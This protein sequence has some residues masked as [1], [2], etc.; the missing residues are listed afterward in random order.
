MTLALRWGRS[1]YE[2]EDALA[3]ERR[4]LSELGVDLRFFAGNDPPLDGV[5]V[6]I[7]PSGS[8][9]DA[10]ILRRAEALRLVVATTSG[11]DHIDVAAARAREI[12]VARCPLA[13]RDA[14]VDTSVGMGL[15][16]VRQLG[17]LHRQAEAGVWARQELPTRATGKIRGMGVGIVGLGVIGSRAAEVWAA[18]GAEVVVCDPAR[19]GTVS[20][21]ELVASCELIT[22]HCSLPPS[23][24][25]LV[26]ANALAAMAD[27]TVL[28]NTARG[29]CLDLEAVEA[30]HHLGGLGLDVFSREPWPHLERLASRP[31]VILTPHAA[32]YHPALGVA[33][34]GEVTRTVAAWQEGQPL[35]HVVWGG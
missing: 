34:A 15:A 24:R 22:L 19:P 1:S 31:H 9:V 30:A 23:S 5:E 27:G 7:V 21:E 16:L 32:G 20:F 29:A 13:R 28:I 18:L 35:E 4:A 8:R 11:H 12:Q 3:L 10:E 33:V 6:L 17:D 14:V 25:N 26:D 2:T